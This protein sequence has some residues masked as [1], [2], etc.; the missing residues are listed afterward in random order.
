MAIDASSLGEQ[1]K[2]F[3]VSEDLSKIFS[4]ILKAGTTAIITREDKYFGIIGEKLFRE[5]NISNPKVKCQPYAVKAPKILI[6]DD[7]SAMAK[8]FSTDGYNELA[9]VDKRD[10]VVGCVSKEQLLALAV[11]HGLVAE[12]SVLSVSRRK[13]VTISST[14]TVGALKGEM[15]RFGVRRVI[16]VDADGKLE[17]IISAYDIGS[18]LMLP[19]GRDSRSPSKE[20]PNL[21]TLKVREFMKPNVVSIIKDKSLRE[22]AKKMVEH[23]VSSVIILD[24]QKP[25]GIVT[26]SDVMKLLVEG[27]SQQVTII[28]LGDEEIVHYQVL[29]EFGSEISERV[30]RFAK[31]RGVELHV[32][33]SGHNCTLH[34]HILTDPPMRFTAEGFKLPTVLSDLK[35]EFKNWVSKMKK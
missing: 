4:Y 7:F 35:R 28:G 16:V 11:A 18:L 34:L 24:G 17:G 12:V 20:S 29:E 30:S 32:K 1:C 22:A 31:V 23:K 5:S 26:V 19:K 9:L 25:V 21:E 2:T 13:L 10:K 15:R 3:D 33:K 27:K 8:K 14:S 6:S